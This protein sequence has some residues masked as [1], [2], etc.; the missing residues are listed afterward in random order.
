MRFIEVVLVVQR[1]LIDM[2]EDADEGRSSR[3]AAT[4]VSGW[5]D[6]ECVV[7][8]VNRESNLLQIVLALTATGRLPGLLH[9]GQQECN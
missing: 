9:S 4:Q 6:A 2:R 5:N 7:V 1:S 8:V 3:V